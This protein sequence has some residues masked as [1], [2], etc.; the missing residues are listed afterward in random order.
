MVRGLAE[1]ADEGDGTVG[2]A[3]KATTAGARDD[4]ITAE[5]EGTHTLAPEMGAELSGGTEAE[6]VRIGGGPQDLWLRSLLATAF[7][8]G[9]GQ[10]RPV[11]GFTDRHEF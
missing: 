3:D 5:A 2:A 11:D 8:D 7:V 1:P 9:F 6:P 10:Q 4:R